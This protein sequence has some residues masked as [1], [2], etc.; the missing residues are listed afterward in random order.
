MKSW[1]MRALAVLG[2]LA[3]WLVLAVLVLLLEGKRPEESA[4]PV[5]T[6]PECFGP[7]K[8]EANCLDA[9]EKAIAEREV[10]KR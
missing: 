4:V 8:A 6:I 5:A 7:D 1:L 3:G 10:G 2:W 9:M